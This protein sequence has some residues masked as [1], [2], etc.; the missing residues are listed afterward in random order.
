MKSESRHAINEIDNSRKNIWLIWER[1]DNMREKRH[2]CFN[3]MMMMS[4]RIHIM[5][6]VCEGVVRWEIP[7]IAKKI[8]RA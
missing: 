8:V 5:S 1:H 4:F 3:N 2:T 6:G 7:L